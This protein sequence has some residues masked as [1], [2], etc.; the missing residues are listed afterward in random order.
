MRKTEQSLAELEKLRAELKLEKARRE[1]AEME[2]SFLKNSAKQRG[3]GAKP[4]QTRKDLLG[5][6]RRIRKVWLSDQSALQTW[7][8]KQGSLLQMAPQGGSGE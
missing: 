5:N 6:Q 3:G 2:A 7:K 1:K 8:C 4:A